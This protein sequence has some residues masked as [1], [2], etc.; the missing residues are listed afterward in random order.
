MERGLEEVSERGREGCLVIDVY[1][2]VT[3]DLDPK[4]ERLWQADQKL[5]TVQST[6]VAAQKEL[7]QV[8]VNV[9]RLE[10]QV[11][12]ARGRGER[13]TGEKEG[14]REGRPGRREEG[15]G[16]REERREEGVLQTR[17][18]SEGDDLETG[19]R[20]WFG[21]EGRGGVDTRRVLAESDDTDNVR[22]P[23]GEGGHGGLGTTVFGHDDDAEGEWRI[24]RDQDFAGG[25]GLVGLQT[26]EGLNVDSADSSS[27][28]VMGE[29]VCV[30]VCVC[31]SVCLCVSA[32]ASVCVL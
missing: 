25:V 20:S 11:V 6:L 15:G 4:R 2:G 13:Q 10:E 29:D 19:G 22:P 14:A 12:K 3:K 32:S 24:P 18:E 30:R 23:G 8:K 27:V 9:R 31:V 26:S 17:I 28:R 7:Q 16:R 21:G 1:A 5:L